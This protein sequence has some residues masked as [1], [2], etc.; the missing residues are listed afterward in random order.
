MAIYASVWDA[1][2][3]DPADRA[4]MKTASALMAVINVRINDSSDSAVADRLGLPTMRV[5]QLRR[6]AINDFT[7]DELTRL[8]RELGVTTTAM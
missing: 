2:E 8:A 5:R 1:L 7:V 4:A 6:G 3:G